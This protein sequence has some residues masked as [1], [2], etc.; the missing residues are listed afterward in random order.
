MLR[1]AGIPSRVAVG[2]IYWNGIFGYH[3]WTEAFLND[4]TALDATLNREVVDAT[5]IKFADAAL[6]TGSAAATFLDLVQVVGKIRLSVEEI[7][8]TSA[9]GKDKEDS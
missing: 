7:K 5:H 9:A 3:M 1:A 6:D 8:P 4:W 2:L